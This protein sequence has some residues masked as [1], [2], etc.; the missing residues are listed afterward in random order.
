MKMTSLRDRETW[1]RHIA[2]LKKRLAH[3]LR[4]DCT[5]SPIFVLGKQRSG[6]SMLMGV[7]HRHPEVLVFDEH[8]NNLAF[9]RF[10][11]RGFERI[12]QILENSRYPAVCIKPICDS[13]RI[14]ELAEMFPT[15]K[16]VWIY[17]DY[18]DVANSSLRKFETPTRAIRLV[19]QGKPGGGWFQEGISECIS[20]EL[21][22][23]FRPELS[24]FDLS[25]LVWWAR[26]KILVDSELPESTNLT[27]LK[28]ETLV[29][30]P[31]VILRW[32]FREIDTEYI[33]RTAQH[34]SARS[35]GR[36]NSPQMDE[37]V[38]SLCED[39]LRSLDKLFV[40]HG[41]EIQT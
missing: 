12:S 39:L 29:S 1:A 18:R 33:E 26:N 11:L 3:P 35:I 36:H 8:K 28:Y 38:R 21:K 24:D 13:H 9:D 31:R 6:T 32:L 4:Q 30:N 14:R 2:M 15:G 5:S 34:I 10:R 17:R 7:F 40:E 16:F 22:K 37:E 27:I 41:P 19:C 20:E 23:R 25:C